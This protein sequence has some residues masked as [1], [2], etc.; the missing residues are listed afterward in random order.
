MA[1]V[2]PFAARAKESQRMLIRRLR[3][4]RCHIILSMKNDK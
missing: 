2:T 4:R 3:R 1:R